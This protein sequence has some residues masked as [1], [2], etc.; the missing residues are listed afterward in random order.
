MI[1]DK[2]SAPYGVF[3]KPRNPRK[4]FRNH[5]QMN[6]EIE[7]VFVLGLQKLKENITHEWS[8]C[9]LDKIEELQKGGFSASDILERIKGALKLL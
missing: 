4:I 7:E 8:K 6:K 9:I 1:K 2:N 5:T 3:I